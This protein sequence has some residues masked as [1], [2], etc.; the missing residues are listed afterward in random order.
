MKKSRF[1]EDRAR[2][3]VAPEKIPNSVIFKMTRSPMPHLITSFSD[4]GYPV[5]QRSFL[6][7]FRRRREARASLQ[8]RPGPHQDGVRRPVL[9]SLWR[10]LLPG[11]GLR[12]QIGLCRGGDGK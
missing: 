4:C 8:G 1:S 3:T 9:Q 6:L 12:D 5:N 10:T 7:Q 2:F 11:E